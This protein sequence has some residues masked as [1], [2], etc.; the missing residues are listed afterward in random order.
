MAY[1]G[2]FHLGETIVLRFVT[3][4]ASEVPTVPNIS[5]DGAPLVQVHGTSG[6]I[7]FGAVQRW[8]PYAD[9]RF[10]VTALFAYKLKLDSKFAAGHYRVLYFWQL[11]SYQGI[12]VDYFTIVP[13]GNA[14]GAVVGLYALNI[15]TGRNLV[16][17]L[18]GG[19]IVKGRNPYV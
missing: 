7:D 13:G 17:H 14:S 9:D 18:D 8:L 16:M 2:T 15:P 19:F 5:V 12:E 3:T 6:L 11:G 10:Q 4:N 1:L